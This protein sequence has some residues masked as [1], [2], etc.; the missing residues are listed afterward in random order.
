MEGQ[1]GKL[2]ERKLKC[3]WLERMLIIV[4]AYLSVLS[5]ARVISLNGEGTVYF[6]GRYFGY[7]L[8]SV[9][10]FAVTAWLLHRYFRLKEKRLRVTSSIGGILLGMAVVYGGYAHY[11]N[12]I[13]LSV[14][15]GIL[16]PFL[17]MGISACTTPICAE[18]LQ[19]PGRVGKWYEA[20]RQTRPTGRFHAFL[21][22]RPR[23]YFFLSWG[24]LMLSYVPIFL[25]QWPGNFVFDSIYQFSEELHDSYSTHH[26]LL[27][28]LM[29]GKAYRLGESMGNVAA[30]C[31]F[32]T[33]L[34]MLILTSAFA[35]LLFYLYQKKVPRCIRIGVL[36]W[37]ALFPMHPAFA[38]SAT[39][40]VLFAAF[41]LYYAI[42]LFRFA[43]DRERFA[44]Y[45][46]AFMILAGVLL[47]LFRNN[48]TY[49]LCASGILMLLYLK[50][51]KAKATYLFVLVAVLLLQSLCNRGLM[52]LTHATSPDTQREK[53]SIP[54]Q[55]MARV[56]SYRKA[57]LAPELYD[58]IC[59]Y[60]PEG[61][62]ASYNPYCADPVKNNANELL[63][64]SNQWNFFKLWVKLG[65]QFPDEYLECLLTNTMGYW[66]PL[67]QGIYVSADVAIYHMLIGTEHEIVKHDYFPLVTGYYNYLLYHLN[68]RHVPIMGYLFRN[69]PYVWLLV[70][71]LLWS[72]YQKRYSLLVWGMLPLMYLG[73]CFLGP[74]A[75]LRY[76]YCLIVCTPLLLHG[77]LHPH[78]EPREE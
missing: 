20:R 13:F 11:V 12:N 21:D 9:L 7:N 57:D 62:V 6:G 60:V 67:N 56:A 58:E 15:E 61:D 59:T 16:Q 47:C 4:L 25:S 31:Q 39:K 48:G 74:M 27:H 68:Y 54:L 66:Y 41:F 78:A 43:V 24:I 5:F 30:G 49:A 65:L 76:V 42:F 19:L 1:S 10:L 55:C 14:P 71:T 64:R 53:M 35:Y 22:G 38:I 69:A 17:V 75:A 8:S 28:T 45:D 50:P 34:Q 46:H 23:C 63:L 40:D 70:L 32:Y 72:I 37:F 29:L 33:L 18:L 52:E 77:L 36:L 44:W 2:P 73:T 3:L 51:R 26:P